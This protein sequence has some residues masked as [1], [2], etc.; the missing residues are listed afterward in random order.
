MLTRFALLRF[1]CLDLLKNKSQP[2]TAAND[3]ADWVVSERE[4]KERLK[5]EK[6]AREVKDKIEV[7]FV[8][9]IM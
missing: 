8:V 5:R 4:M 1:L 6:E 7:F 9:V 2:E 3:A